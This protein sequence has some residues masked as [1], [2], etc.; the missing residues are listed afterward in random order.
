ML[1]SHCFRSSETR[2]RARY[3]LTW[4][5]FT[6]CKPAGPAGAISDHAAGSLPRLTSRV[7]APARAA[8][9]AL[10]G[11]IE[12]APPAAGPERRRRL[13]PPAAR[14][15]PAPHGT[16]NHWQPNEGESSD[17]T[18]HSVAEYMIS[19]P[20]E[21]SPSPPRRHARPSVPG[22]GDVSIGPQPL[23]RSA[24]ATWPLANRQRPRVL[25][26]KRSCVRT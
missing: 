12:H 20:E 24:A 16:P 15:A 4:L 11:S 5:G 14:S 10:I 18:S 26:S 19:R 3:W 9:Q 7:S 21:A 22:A 25:I 6:I 1:H 23:R 17:L 8:V 2:D 13:D